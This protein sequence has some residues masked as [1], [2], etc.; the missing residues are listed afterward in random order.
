THTGE[1]EMEFEGFLSP[2]DKI[3]VKSL[4]K[5][6]GHPLSRMLHAAL[7]NT[8][9]Y[10][11]Q[12]FREETSKGIISVIKGKE[13]RIGSADFVWIK[14]EDRRKGNDTLVFISIDA[15]VKGC[16]IFKNKYRS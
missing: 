13:V 2:E 4:V 3:Y 5:N 11:V 6:S 1:A 10:P 15:Q 9:E 8:T 14:K 12:S 7:K 16:Y